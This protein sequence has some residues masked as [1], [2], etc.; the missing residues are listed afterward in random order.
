MTSLQERLDEYITVRR[1]LGFGLV[2]PARSL[3][4]FVAFAESE[5]RDSIT[6][7]LAMRWAT[8][9]ARAQPATW[10][11]RLGMV[12]RFA[13]WCATS[14]PRTEIPPDGLLPYRY[15]RTR[16]HIYSDE[17]IHRIV[18]AAGGLPSSTGLRARTYATIFG[19]LAVTGMRLS[20]VV[21][22]DRTDVDLEH[23][24]VTV[25]RSKFGSS[26]FVPVHPST[27]E[28]LGA[29]AAQRDGLVA[30]PFTASFFVSEGGARITDCMAR[31]TF[32]VVS[33]RIGLRASAGGYRHGRGPRLHDIRHRFAVI[34]MLD[35]YRAGVDVEREIPKLSTYLGHVHVNDTYWYI[36]A[37]PELLAFA[38]ARLDNAREGG[39]P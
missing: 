5:G 37:V 6:T 21:A 4:R 33:R 17:E 16:P 19:L 25:R 13:A 39:R 34:T 36:E 1:S 7:D 14:D 18:A 10:A 28:A 20:E 9:S 12:R 15:R 2:G 26:R 27:V 3:G 23:G 38:A 30:A 29:Y 35:W 32:A 24:I 22:L 8:K 11:S 31:Y